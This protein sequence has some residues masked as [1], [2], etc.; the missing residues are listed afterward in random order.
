MN[1]I[2]DPATLAYLEE[3][4]YRASLPKFV[5][6]EGKLRPFPGRSA[7]RL[8]WF[9]LR[10][11]RIMASGIIRNAFHYGRLSH[12]ARLKKTG[13]GKTALVLGNGP[14]Q[15]FMDPKKLLRFIQQDNHFFAVNFYNHNKI[16]SSICPN[17]YVI[18]DPYT[19][20]PNAPSFISK[21]NSALRQYFQENR[22][23]K[24][25]VPMDFD[26]DDCFTEQAIYFN[27]VEA[28]WWTKNINPLFP[29][30]YLSMTLYKALAIACFLG[31]EKIYILGMDNTYPHDIFVDRENHVC[32]VERHTGGSFNVADIERSTSGFD[33]LID[34]SPFY[35]GTEDV[36]WDLCFLFSDLRLFKDNPIV[37]LDPYSLNNTFPKADRDTAM[38]FLFHET[39]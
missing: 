27:D 7:I 36:L 21:S 8:L 1:K 38:N 12:L 34:Q 17:Y 25:C 9:K 5:L 28:S 10:S 29:R 11:V 37:N 31:Y 24:I 15:G 4:K 39:M 3:N 18:S 14:S 2:I 16:L 20:D 23:I 30:G 32:N 33:H 6:E 22:E 13:F 19:L 35:K 26:L